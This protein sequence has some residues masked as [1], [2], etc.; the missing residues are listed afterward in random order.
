MGN[1]TGW[2]L[3]TA[4]VVAVGI[5]LYLIVFNPSPSPP[6]ETANP[7]FM[8]LKPIFTPLSKLVTDPTLDADAAPDYQRG[9]E[10]YVAN[11][12]DITAVGEGDHWEDLVKADNAWTDPG[13]KKLVELYECIKAGTRKKGM[14]YLSSYSEKELK[15]GWHFEAPERFWK[16]AVSLRLLASMYEEKKRFAESAAVIKDMLV[17]GRHMYDEHGLAQMGLTG[18]EIQEFAARELQKLY[19]KWKG[20]PA[21]A[22]DPLAKYESEISCILLT[23]RKKKEILWDNIPKT[24]ENGQPK[25]SP[26]DVFN[27]VMKEEDAAW[28]AQAIIA[29]GAV[30]FR[31]SARGDRR[32]ADRLITQYL[33]SKD[34]LLAAAAKVA[35]ELTV[36][37]FRGS[38]S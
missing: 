15:F 38:A 3:A 21:D 35:K 9:I 30:R 13:L 25:F 27:M 18:L 14:K 1:K 32:M 28:K 16:I 23:Y 20:A 12:A 31:A 36:E 10:L 22:M 37:Q 11:S 8:E 7:G 26:G 24:A 4:I 34:P 17:L 6:A 19:R 2:I 5:A 29:L 33:T